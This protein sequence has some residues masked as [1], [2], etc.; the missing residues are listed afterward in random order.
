MQE[1]DEGKRKGGDVGEARCQARLVSSTRAAG[2]DSNA[3]WP[4]GTASP[5]DK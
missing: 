4:K 2:R 3:K 5:R 1:R